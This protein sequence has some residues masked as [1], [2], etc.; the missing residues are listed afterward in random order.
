G[1]GRAADS[2]SD[3]PAVARAAARGTAHTCCDSERIVVAREPARDHQR[4]PRHL[5]PERLGGEP[6][7][8]ARAW[9]PDPV[10]YLGSVAGLARGRG[11]PPRAGALYVLREMLPSVRGR[12]SRAARLRQRRPAALVRP[13]MD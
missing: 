11:V 2:R 4:R 6:R 5:P 13:G 10:A 9:A 3:G 7:P 12:S 1:R 8:V